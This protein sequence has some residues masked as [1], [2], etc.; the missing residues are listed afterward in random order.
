MTEGTRALEGVFKRIMAEVARQRSLTCS[1]CLSCQPCCYCSSLVRI[2]S[3]LTLARLPFLGRDHA[4][5][6]HQ[7]FDEN[8]HKFCRSKHFS[9]LI[10]S[11]FSS[12]LFNEACENVNG[13][14]I[15]GCARA[16]VQSFPWT[17]NHGVSER[18]RK[19]WGDDASQRAGTG[20]RNIEDER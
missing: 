8:T 10:A 2:C 14:I 5:R 6:A 13:S 11:S 17:I 20:K 4:A 9:K 19:C 16:C 18:I 1:V 3:T 12:F 7:I 15:T